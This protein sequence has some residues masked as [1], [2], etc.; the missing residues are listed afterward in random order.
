MFEETFGVEG[1]PNHLHADNGAAM[2]S[3]VLQN[4]CHDL[5]VDMSHNRPSVS[6][7]NPFKE[8]EFRTMKHRP[9]YP[10]HFETIQQARE[11]LEEYVLWFNTEHHHSALA[12]HTP[13]SVDDG[14]WTQINE[15][16]AKV[17]DA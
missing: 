14:S 13:Q 8:A 6:N 17:L 1:I 3:N 12:W 11:W 2:T 9:N 4:L 5:H 10:G 15:A 16:R 7:D